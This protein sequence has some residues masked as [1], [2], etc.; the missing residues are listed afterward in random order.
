MS[1]GM[2][3]TLEVGP[4]FHFIIIL[5]ERLICINLLDNYSSRRGG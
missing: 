3:H 2:E 5:A 1:S 4:L